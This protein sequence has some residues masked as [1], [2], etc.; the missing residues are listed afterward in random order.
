MEEYTVRQIR[1]ALIAL[2]NSKTKSLRKKMSFA[3]VQRM[4]DYVGWAD[5]TVVTPKDL[6][7]LPSL[8]RKSVDI[9]FT[10][11]HRRAS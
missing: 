7:N 8:G 1:N 2:S 6:E 4:L 3:R 11:I 5:A 10:E 9:L